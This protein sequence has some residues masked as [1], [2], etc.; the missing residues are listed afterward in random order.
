MMKTP[1]ESL[2]V[3]ITADIRDWSLTKTDAWIYG[4]IV[5]WGSDLEE[6]CKKNKLGSLDRERLRLLGKQFRRLR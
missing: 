6:V 2:K 1:I 4:I 5:G 3:V